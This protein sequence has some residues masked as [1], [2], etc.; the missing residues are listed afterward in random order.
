MKHKDYS[1][2]YN[3]G[4]IAVVNKAAGLAVIGERWN[5]EAPSLDKL[6]EK[7]FGEKLF[8]VHRIDKDTTGLVVFAFSPE[9]HRAL[10]LSFQERLVS[11]AYI[12]VS[13]GGSSLKDGQRFTVTDKLLPEAGAGGRTIA[14]KI[15]GKESVTEFEVLEKFKGFTLLKAEPLTGRMHQIRVH[16]SVNGLPIVCDKLYGTAKPFFLSQIKKNWRGDKFEER[17]LI[18]R[19]ALHAQYLSFKHPLSQKDLSLTAELPKDMQT[20]ITQLRKL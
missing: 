6:L 4:E 5:R 20:L 9:V 3:D 19:Q 16:L 18:S 8:I 2:I 14:D 11:K 7:E 10:S 1:I 17:P 13:A 15:N 12:A